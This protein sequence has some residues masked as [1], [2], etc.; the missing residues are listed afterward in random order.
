MIGRLLPALLA[1]AAAGAH[2]GSPDVFHEG[3]AG[4]YRLLVV[5]RP[6][7]VIPGVAEVEIRAAAEG[8]RE[9][10]IVPL[11]ASGEGA[12]F[13]PAPDV[14]LRSKEDPQFFRGSLWMMEAG[15][16]QVRI[17]LE[18]EQG[19]GQM[20]VPVPALAVRPAVMQKTL[21]AVLFGLMLVLA[22]GL[23]SIAGASV[24][25]AQL[26]PG[27][28]PGRERVKRARKVTLGT[29]A[30]VALALYLGYQW[31]GAEAGEYQRHLYKPL[32]LR[33]SLEAGGKLVLRIENPR[34]LGRRV[35]DLA[36][37]HGHL[38]HLFLVRMQEMDAL[39]HLHPEQSGP[40]VFRQPLPAVPAGRYKIFADVVHRDGLPETMTGEIELGA[41]AGAPLSGD[42]S[43]GSAPWSQAITWAE[44]SLPL[45]AHRVHWFRF[46]VQ[47]EQGRPAEDLELY[48]GMPGHAVFLKRDASVFAHVHPSGSAPMAA[49]QLLAAAD[50]HA[51]HAAQLPPEV[52][53]PYGFPSPGDYR[54]FVQ[55]KRRGRV[56]TAA[57][58][59]R[60]E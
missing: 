33:A 6:P 29:A 45:V 50:P 22:G 18:G 59:A 10:R 58:D 36:A 57:F 43:G 2:V 27:S 24:R 31:W 55:L 17:T 38:M 53:F 37:D 49:V 47:D 25:E 14:A 48:M 44:S 9:V 35:D 42:D 40:G 34:W 32:E 4:P 7:A 30:V 19:R 11:P 3:S 16:W 60:V 39:W 5:I 28:E 54:I 46:R 21:G 52:S 41:V 23:A 20:A 26:E 1:A 15:S 12:K 56:E 51:G 8:V 13:A